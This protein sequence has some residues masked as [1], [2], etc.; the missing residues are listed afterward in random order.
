MAGSILSPAAEQDIESILIWT[1][2]RFGE[3]VRLRYEALLIRAILDVAQSPDRVGSVARPEIAQNVRTYHLY[4]SRN[5]VPAGVRRIGKPRHFLLYRV[6]Q[7]ACI[8][9]VRVLHDS[10]ELE[11]H[12]PEEHEF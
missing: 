1:H 8:E 9:I 3:K 4:H 11:R 7:N 2:E 12:V 10:M 5:R 6:A